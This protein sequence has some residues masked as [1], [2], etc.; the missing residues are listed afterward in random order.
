MASG[1]IPE[2]AEFDS[3]TAQLHAHSN[4]DI[5]KHPDDRSRRRFLKA[6]SVVGLAVAF[7]S[8]TIGEEFA[9]SKSTTAQEENNMNQTSAIQAADKATIRGGP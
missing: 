8:A 5:M 2:R 7:R 9:D 4:G 6:S 1:L 3:N